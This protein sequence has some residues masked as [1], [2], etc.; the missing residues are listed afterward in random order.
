MKTQ[1]QCLTQTV[2]S[3]DRDCKWQAHLQMMEVDESVP[4]F[5]LQVIQ[6]EE[7]ILDKRDSEK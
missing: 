7:V 2:P 6:N 4:G 3:I 1:K 5:L